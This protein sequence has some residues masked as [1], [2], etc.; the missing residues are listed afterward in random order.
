MTF[1]ADLDVIF[2]AKAGAIARSDKLEKLAQS[3]IARLSQFTAGGRLYDVDA[4]L[5]PEGKNSPLVV[6]IDAYKRYLTERASLWERQSLTRMRFC[7][8]NEKVGRSVLAMVTRWLYEAPL[9]KGWIK[10][11]ADMR[12]KTEARSRASSHDFY[13]IKLGQGGMVDIEFLAQIFQLAFGR[14]R[15]EMRSGRTPEIVQR[16]V[17][18]DLVPNSTISLMHAYTMYRKIETFMRI[19]LEERSTILPEG[20]KLDYLGKVLRGWSGNQLLAY[21]SRTTREV[22]EIFLQVCARL[23]TQ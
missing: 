3:V 15:N 23:S 6:D 17:M 4:R 11:I 10:E 5:R 9:P 8:G 18:Q 20:E 22:R 21:V 1:D 13:D 19:S 16:A 7:C 2:V 12:R 14:S